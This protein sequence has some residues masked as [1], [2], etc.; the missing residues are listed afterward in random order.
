MKGLDLLYLAAVGLSGA[1]ARGVLKGLGPDVRLRLEAA[2]PEDLAPGWVWVHA[3][4]VGE[5]LLAEGLVGRL[6]ERGH[7]VH[8]TTGTAA[9][10]ALLTDRLPAWDRGRG[11]LSGGAF[12][13]DDPRG[14]RPFLRTPP[15]AF[16]ALETELWPNLIREL[17]RRGIPRAVVNGRLTARSLRRGGP[18][19]RLAASRLSL[20][21]ARDAE[22]LEAFRS[23][24]ASGAALGGNL[25]AD[26]PAPRPLHAGWEALRQAWREDPVV[27][28]GNTVAGEEALVLEAFRALRRGHPGARLILAPRR[29]G[30]FDG[31]ADLL[32]S[33]GW[34]FRRASGPWPEAAA[35]WREVPVL[36]LDT[37]GELAAAYREGTVA[38]V[39]GGWTW[40]GG[41]NPVEPAA[42]GLPVLLG[43]GHDNFKDLVNPLVLAGIVQICAAPDLV[44][45]LEAAV[46]ASP[47][48]ASPRPLPEGL[49]G[50]LERTLLLLDPILHAPR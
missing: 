12:P 22:S 50:A 26:L 6:A 11:L 34:A 33:E 35:A 37:L 43:P 1:V 47:L 44:P 17:A 24:G 30:R 7:R 32:A 41:H 20:V 14:L 16:I 2:P 48:R 10:L 28:A 45:A 13:L 31:V 25:K 46:A 40:E 4:S 19:I 15:G 39:G 36:L 3:V 8:L 27:V 29:P 18:W 23:L 49:S 5:L 9:G 38:L 42:A 21:A